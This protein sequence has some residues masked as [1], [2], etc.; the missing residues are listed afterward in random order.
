MI[1]TLDPTE[2]IQVLSRNYIGH[3]AY[4]YNQAPFVVPITYFFDKERNCIIGYSAEG[5]KI[6]AMRKNDQV[7]MEVSEITSVN[8]WN[9]IAVHGTFQELSGSEAKAYLHDFSLG[10]KD[11]IMQKEQRKLDFI[12]EFSSKIY[13]DDLPVVFLIHIEEITGRMRRN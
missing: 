11:L 13:K 6:T 10:V 12:N 4:I 3:V 5:H 9:C 1:K 8:H 2:K 7:A